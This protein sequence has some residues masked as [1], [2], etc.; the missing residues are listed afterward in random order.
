MK[1][2]FALKVFREE[3]AEEVYR[4]VVR[5]LDEDVHNMVLRRVHPKWGSVFRRSLELSDKN[6]SHVGSR[7]LDILHVA[8]SLTLGCDRFVSFDE[9]QIRLAHNCKLEIVSM[10]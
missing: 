3:I 10:E 4:R 7:S 8:I 2:A 6:T 1:N 9:R 5:A